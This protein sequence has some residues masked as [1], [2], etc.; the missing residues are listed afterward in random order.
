MPSLLLLVGLRIHL[1]VNTT[2]SHTDMSYWEW[3][4]QYLGAENCLSNIRRKTHKLLTTTMLLRGERSV[5]RAHA[6]IK[7]ELQ[8]I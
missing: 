3:Q 8:E 6:S 1:P 7:M 4:R 2:S 5:I